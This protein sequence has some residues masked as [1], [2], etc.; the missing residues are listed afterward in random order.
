MQL[1]NTL[2]PA[3]NPALHILVLRNCLSTHLW[4]VVLLKKSPVIHYLSFPWY[5]HLFP[6]VTLPYS[7][8][9][10]STVG[11]AIFTSALFVL[12][13]RGWPRKRSLSNSPPPLPSLNNF[14]I[15]QTNRNW[16]WR[17]CLFYKLHTERM[18]MCGW[19]PRKARDCCIRMWTAFSISAVLMS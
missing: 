3:L 18:I 14:S 13:Y 12:P 9:P 5:I 11:K 1:S 19:R 8:Q 7:L 15:F 16:M 6:T 17:T 2:K 10:R 4:L